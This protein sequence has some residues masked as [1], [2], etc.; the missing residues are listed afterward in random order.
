VFELEQGEGGA[1]DPGDCCGAEDD[2][3][4]GLEGDRQ[5]GVGVFGNAEAVS[6]Q[7]GWGLPVHPRA[8]L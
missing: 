6:S 5:Q 8:G 2:P 3:A 4:Q 1:G 7:L